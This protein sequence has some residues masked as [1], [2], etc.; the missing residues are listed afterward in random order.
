[1]TYNTFYKCQ[2]QIVGQTVWKALHLQLVLH[3]MPI[4]VV[5][6]LECPVFAKHQHSFMRFSGPA[7]RT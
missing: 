2:Q 5:P 7:K 1:M 6:T 3:N 4:C